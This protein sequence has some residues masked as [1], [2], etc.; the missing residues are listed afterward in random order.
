LRRGF[1]DF[2]NYLFVITTNI[3]LDHVVAAP[4]ASTP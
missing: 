3:H 1:F 4:F 2:V